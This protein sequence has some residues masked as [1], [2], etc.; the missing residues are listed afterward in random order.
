MVKFTDEK[1]RKIINERSTKDMK[2]MFSRYKNNSNKTSKLWKIIHDRLG[3]DC[4]PFDIKRKY[5]DA[6]KTFRRTQHQF[7]KDGSRRAVTWLF[8]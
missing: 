2:M 4:V 3:F 6:L 7:S 1:I 5:N 8:L